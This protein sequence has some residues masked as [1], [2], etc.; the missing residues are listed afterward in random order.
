MRQVHWG[1]LGVVVQQKGYMYV[2]RALG[3]DIFSG[4][5]LEAPYHSG[6]SWFRVGDDDGVVAGSGLHNHLQSSGEHNTSSAHS[7]SAL[8]VSP[9]PALLSQCRVVTILFPYGKGS[10]SGATREGV[11]SLGHLGRRVDSGISRGQGFGRGRGPS[12]M[13][14]VRVSSGVGGWTSILLSSL[15]C[16]LHWTIGPA[17]HSLLFL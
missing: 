11:G 14:G 6:S 5:A 15:H 4:L 3:T 8:L 17:I 16:S 13:W 7:R 12:R 9:S 1:C 2:L 10:G